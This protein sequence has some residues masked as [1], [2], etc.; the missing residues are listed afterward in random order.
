MKGYR[1]VNFGSDLSTDQKLTQ[2]APSLGTDHI[3]VKNV[4]S[5]GGALRQ[6]NRQN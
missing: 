2:F 1:I 4:V 3:L 5:M 6:P